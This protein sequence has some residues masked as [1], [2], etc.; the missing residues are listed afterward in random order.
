MSRDA[1]HAFDLPPEFADP[2][3]AAVI[4]VP[5]PYD[6]T[7]SW[8][9]GADRGP[10]ALIDASTYVELLDTETWSQPYRR[11]IAEAPPVDYSGPPEGLADAVESVVSGLLEA[12]RLP[13]VLGGEHSVTV[14][15]VR[16]AARHAPGLSV[17]Q[18]D[19]HSDTRETYQG[20]PYNHACVMARVREVCPIVQ[21]GIR[22]VDPVEAE[23][24]EL[25]R[26]FFAH[27]IVGRD[28]EW[29]DRAASLLSDD[30]YITLD[31]DAFDPSVLPATGTPEPGGLDW[32]GVTRLIDRVAS[33]RRIVGFDVV[34]LCPSPEHH[35]SA[36][37]AAKLV[38]RTLAAAF[39]HSPTADRFP[40]LGRDAS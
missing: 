17:L 33:G 13:V 36:F 14:G 4:L 22:S 23:A 29:M 19:A 8:K 24:M 5:V 1:A 7:S 12:G 10:A 26:V 31:L 35:A 18:V 11:G 38:Y 15:A 28:A 25:G 16:A 27:E 21:V 34:E 2:D 20:S 9:K 30:V 6:E 39:S 3:T 40:A 32:Y 37:T